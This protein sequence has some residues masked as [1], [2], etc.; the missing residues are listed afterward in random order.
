MVYGC[1]HDDSDYWTKNEPQHAVNSLS[2]LVVHI[3]P[4]RWDSN[5]QN[6]EFDPVTGVFGQFLPPRRWRR[7][8]FVE[9]R[10]KRL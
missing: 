3:S 9:F 2:H 8:P 4:Y 6:L 7:G 10:F 5:I 1:N